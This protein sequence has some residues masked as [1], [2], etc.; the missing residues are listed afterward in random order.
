MHPHDL[1][2]ACFG[3]LDTSSKQLVRSRRVLAEVIAAAL[4]QGV[5]TGEGRRRLR[6]PAEALSAPGT[7]P[8]KR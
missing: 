1:V 7:L 4:R 5:L 6:S 8:P 2:D 3:L